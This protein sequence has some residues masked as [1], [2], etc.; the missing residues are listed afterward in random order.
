MLVRA[1]MTDGTQHVSEF[2]KLRGIRRLSADV[3]GGRKA[4]PVWDTVA[5]AHPVSGEPCQVRTRK[6]VSGRLIASLEVVDAEGASIQMVDEGAA[7]RITF[8]ED[9]DIPE[10]VRPNVDYPLHRSPDGR[11]FVVVF[12]NSGAGEQDVLHY[13]D[14]EAG[15]SEDVPIGVMGEE[16]GA[17]YDDEDQ[18]S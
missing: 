6:L 8:T 1:T 2:S 3:F 17:P 9:Q 7:G 5:E 10:G 4:F 14:E 13:I 18:I 16:N 12:S 11:R 15:V